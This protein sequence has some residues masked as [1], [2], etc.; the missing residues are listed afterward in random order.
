VIG[1][2]VGPYKVLSKLG[3]GG[4]GVVYRA[5]DTRLHRP[6][7]VKFLPGD[8]A[9]NADARARFEREAR[10][11]SALDHP[12]ICTIYD[13]GEHEGRPF[14]VMALLEGQTLRHRLGS[15]L[16]LDEALGFALQ[17]VDG[18]D[19]AHAK[20]IIHRDIKP[21]NLF[22]TSRGEVK[23]LDF[24]LA[25]AMDANAIDG[26]SSH[27][28]ANAP[29]Y[30]QPSDQTTVLRPA[31]L[32]TPGQALGT[33]AYMSP[34][35]AR[36]EPLD[37]RSDL[38][39]VGAVLYELFTGRPAFEG[40]TMAVV[41][42]S[43]LEREPPP[44]R[45]INPDVPP[46]IE[47]ILTKA[48]EKDRALRYQSIA[49]LRADLWRVKRNRTNQTFSTTAITAP[50][51]RGARSV[52]AAVA[53]G[54]IVVAAIA[55]WWATRGG[56]GAPIESIAVLPFENVGGDPNTEYL[57]D[58]LTDSLINALSQVQG[59]RVVPRSTMFTYK[60]RAAD[61][62]QVG[63]DLGVH[64]V[65]SGQVTQRGDTLVVRA[66]LMDVSKVSNLW[67][68]TYDRKMA[69][70]LTIEKDI[71]REIFGGLRVRLSGDDTRRLTSRS[72]T[73]TEALNLYYRGLYHRQQTTEEGFRASIRYFQQAV[74]LDSRFPLAYVGLSDSY[75]SLGYLEVGAPA[76]IW[77]R[78]KAAADAA[79]AIDPDLAEA[80]AARGHA[81]FRYDWNLETAKAALERS[82][83]LNPRYAIARHWYAHYLA[84][85]EPGGAAGVETRKAIELEPADL[86]LNAHA[87]FT[88]RGPAQTAQL[89]RALHNVRQID[90][91][92][93]VIHIALSAQHAHKKDDHGV[94]RE[95]ERAVERSD[96][97]PLALQ[98][99]GLFHAARGNRREAERIIARLEQ[100]SYPPPMYIA[101]IYRRLG[102]HDKAFA[103]LE[104]GFKE[105]DGA[106]IDLVGR[107]W[108]EARKTDPRI[109]DLANRMADA[110]R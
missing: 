98:A 37:A 101:Q 42:A 24:G 62:Q 32:T 35:Q 5:E 100:R 54:L 109:Q 22:V 9:P 74:D 95:L 65:L 52:A 33:A 46:E 7:A 60:N 15:K 38:F 56:G 4:M 76:E 45:Q 68:D 81:L 59:L 99:L 39:S 73:N 28:A 104:R 12:N 102:D 57:S 25:K 92:F 43:L 50:Q 44:A 3:E 41:F 86:M 110:K 83:A 106:M 8:V 31:E 48:L 103:W 49:D 30:V 34:E 71:A 55:A 69:D 107:A 1:Q 77:P 23:I 79:L 51:R 87:I 19:T 105:R 11:A 20:G 26:A 2:M 89:E 47:A 58:G 88:S 63:R 97:M 14:I 53:I 16:T 67:G 90:P 29:H 13:V 96:G 61:Q 17:I 27:G 70:L 80:H 78:A 93:W 36:G 21:A 108:A 75:G 91:D 18:L 82:I 84:V 94:L 72:T 64:A 10:A 40:D 66:N 6:V 85:D